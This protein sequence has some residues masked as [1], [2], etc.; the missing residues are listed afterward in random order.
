MKLIHNVVV[1]GLAVAAISV[2][3]CSSSHGSTS[4]GTGSNGPGI[5]G[6][7]SQDGTGQLSMNLDIG[8]GVS[9]TSFQYVISG[10]NT[11][12]PTTITI[13]DAQSLEFVVGGIVA[14]SG[15]TL[16]IN[17]SDSAG[18]TCT[19]ATTTA[20]T[21]TAGSVTQTTL[22]VTCTA[23]P[24]AAIQADVNTGSLEVDASVTLVGTA[25]PVCPGINSFSISPA[26]LA[27]G[28]SGQLSMADTDSTATIL[29][30]ATPAGAIVFGA[31]NTATSSAANPTYACTNSAPQATVTVTIT[32]ASST[33]AALCSGKMFETMSALV[34][35]EAPLTFT[36]PPQFGNPL[37]TT[38]C[39]TAPN[40]TCVN[41]N[42]DL[43]NCGSCGH[44][45]PAAPAGSTETCT[46]GVC[47][48]AAAPP[49][50]CTTTPCAAS[51]VTC[52]NN[53]TVTDGHC[54]QTEA[55]F[56]AIDIASGADTAGG[57]ATVNPASC[58]ACLVNADCLDN[59]THFTG[60]ECEDFGTGTF[61]NASTTVNSATTCDSVVSC[62]ISSHCATTDNSFCYCGNGGGPSSACVTTAGGNAANG[63]C[64]AQE[65]AGLPDAQTDTADNVGTFYGTKADP[66]GRANDIF[67]CALSAGCTQC[68]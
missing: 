9:L 34:N 28:Q 62:V 23:P 2:A 31:G 22:A 1:A 60:R 39:G 13:G 20:F 40:Q 24:D 6:H 32:P 49:T 47:G 15:Y 63:P 29:W 44:V 64:I 18:D 14:G 42:S 66:S 53:S 10:P 25:A 51:Q 16:T 67:A 50:V 12:G 65:V 5:L 41:T 4:T 19:G 45:C 59:G 8:P 61:V 46:A 68:L 21:I 27:A 37:L 52:S 17:G 54:T 36:C 11:Y 58:Y 7:Q 56:A 33:A 3:A 30:T 55:D 48:A 26:E 38:T 43:N 35:C 57:D